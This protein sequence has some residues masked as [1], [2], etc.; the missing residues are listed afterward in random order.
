MA[1]AVVNRTIINGYRNVVIRVTDLSDG[2]GLTNYKAYDA[3]SA[4][5]FGVQAFGQTIYPGIHTTI[6]GLDYDIQDMKLQLLWDATT[7]E[8]I[9]N[10]GNAPEDFSWLRFG[11]VT[12]PPGLAGATGSIL[13]T[14]VNAAAQSTFSLVLSLRKNVP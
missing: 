8:P 1:D 11:G 12:C 2:T 3:T 4:G 5:A 14:T 7:P 10:L 13:L 6:V 9:F